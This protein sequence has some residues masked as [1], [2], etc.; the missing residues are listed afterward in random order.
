MS[1]PQPCHTEFHFVKPF[2]GVVAKSYNHYPLSPHLEEPGNYERR[3]MFLL[4]IEEI[5]QCHTNNLRLT[6]Y[7]ILQSNLKTEI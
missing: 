2:G 6:G 4:I 7:C 5:I 3:I 1:D